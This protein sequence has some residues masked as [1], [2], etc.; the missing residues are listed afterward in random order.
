LSGCG[1]LK[2]ITSAGIETSR[3]RWKIS[4]PTDFP[5]PIEDD[6]PGNPI[7]SIAMES[8]TRPKEWLAAFRKNSKVI[9]KGGELSGGLRE[10]EEPDSERFFDKD[11]SAYALHLRCGDQKPRNEKTQSS[12][13][14]RTTLGASRRLATSGVGDT[15][16]G[17]R[18]E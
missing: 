15:Y 2:R 8:P 9:A 5:D 16:Q 13:D 3:L 17:P 4:W 14:H 11:I 7:D 18:T 1:E 10:A 12:S 6:L